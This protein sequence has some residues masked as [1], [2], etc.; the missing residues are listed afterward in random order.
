MS[1]LARGGLLLLPIAAA[2][3]M[4]RLAR[5][6]AWLPV[7]VLLALLAAVIISPLV[8]AAVSCRAE[9]VAD[10]FASRARSAQ[11]LAAV[12]RNARKS[13]A[14]A[15]WACTPDILRRAAGWSS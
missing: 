13:P 14:D 6:Y 5:Q 15:S 8:D 3:A 9:L 1:P 4:V 7:A 10:D 2:I 12:L 11:Q